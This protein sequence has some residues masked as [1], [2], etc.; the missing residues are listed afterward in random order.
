MGPARG[1]APSVRRG[2]ASGRNSAPAGAAR[3]RL[4]PKTVNSWR[5]RGASSQKHMRRLR[6]GAFDYGQANT[7]PVPGAASSKSN[8]FLTMHSLWKTKA[9]PGALLGL[10]AALSLRAQT[11]PDA[12]VR[13]PG[14]DDNGPQV[15]EDSSSPA[16]TSPRRTRRWPCLSP[17]SA[18]SRSRTA[19]CRPTRSTSCAKSRRAYPASAARTRISNRARRSGAP[20]CLIHGLPALVLIDGRRVAYKFR[21]TPRI[22]PR[23]L[24]TSNMI[25]V[26]AI[27]RIEVVTGGAF[28]P[29]ATRWTRS[30]G[31]VI[32]DAKE[33]LQRL[34]G[35]SRTT[36]SATT[37]ATT[38]SA[39]LHRGRR[40]RREDLGDALGRVFPERPHHLREPAV[41]QS[42]LR[43][44]VLSG[45]HRHLQRGERQRRVLQADRRPQRTP[46]RGGLHHRPAGLD[47]LLHRCRQRQQTRRRCSRS[48]T[49]STWP[50]GR[51]FSKATSARARQSTSSTMCSETP[52]CSLAT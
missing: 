30:A 26:A 11:A 5:F 22:R 45:H 29:H 24:S 4:S 51:R 37:T 23:N 17:S 8:L 16:R 19:A 50:R 1:G 41:H 52:W 9:A 15:L 18:S 47:G 46:G 33:G 34:G 7:A 12:S 27:E 3:I 28:G 6:S 40:Q 48:R 31:V 36:A 35:E 21:R 38:P 2:A 14:A 43:D 42:L 25:P 13:A 32:C 39:W 44:D 49:G 20:R 10:C